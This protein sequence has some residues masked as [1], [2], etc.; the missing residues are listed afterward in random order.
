M[1]RNKI[2]INI[3]WSLL[4]QQVKIANNGAENINIEVDIFA[5][6][7]IIFSILSCDFNIHDDT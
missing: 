5:N 7:S 2:K 3:Y 1:T 6:I 4:K